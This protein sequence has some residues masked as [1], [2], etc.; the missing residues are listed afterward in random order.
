MAKDFDEVLDSMLKND[1]RY[2]RNV[3]QFMREALEYTFKSLA[4]ANDLPPGKHISGEDL[5][6][7]VRDYALGQYGPMAKTVLNTWGVASSEDLGNIVFNLIDHGL[8]AKSE[9]DS[10]E[11]FKDVLD[12]EDAFVRPFLPRRKKGKAD[13]DPNNN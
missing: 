1:T 2:D 6:A 8:F 9:T 10:I 13:A 5:V 7:G 12:F 11:D 3:Y 4:K